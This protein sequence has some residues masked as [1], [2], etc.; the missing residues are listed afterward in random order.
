MDFNTLTI[1]FLKFLTNIVGNWGLAI[2]VLTLIIRCALWPANVAQ[3]KSMK[4]M[5]LM[6]TKIKLIQE[7]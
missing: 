1:L 5:Q 3:Q 2:I 4:T 6:Q 7:R